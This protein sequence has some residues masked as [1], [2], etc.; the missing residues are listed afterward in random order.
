MGA[1]GLR[2]TN[3]VSLL[4][5]WRNIHD[6]LAGQRLAFKTRLGGFALRDGVADALRQANADG[7]AMLAS[8]SAAQWHEPMPGGEFLYAD[9]VVFYADAAGLGQLA[10]RLELQPAAKDENVVVVHPKNP[11][12]FRLTFE[13]VPGVLC[14]NSVLTFLDLATP[15]AA[16][17][18]AKRITVAP[19]SRQA[20]RRNRQATDADGREEE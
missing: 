10:R 20:G 15:Q 5:H 18:M 7:S 13:P 16:R 1:G 11:D 19:R 12:V 17:E 9:K 14:S 3:T 8:F 6:P 2:L 4:Q